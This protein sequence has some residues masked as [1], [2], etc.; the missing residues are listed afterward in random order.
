MNR[1]AALGLIVVLLS[2]LFVVVFWPKRQADHHPHPITG[3]AIECRRVP[4]SGNR[5]FHADLPNV[6]CLRI[7]MKEELQLERSFDGRMANLEGWPIV[8]SIEAAPPFATMLA[9]K[10]RRH[11]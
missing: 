10:A 1:P 4:S 9:I 8:R 5:D 11:L 6:G 3:Q 2:L 7:D